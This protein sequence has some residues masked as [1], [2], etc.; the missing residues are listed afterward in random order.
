MKYQKKSGVYQILNL[1]NQKCYVGSSKNIHSRW[2]DHRSMLRNNK[3]GNKHLQNAWNK[4][5]EDEFIFRILEQI[6]YDKTL[7]EQREDYWI[8]HFDSTNEEK[9]YN[10][11]TAQ[12]GTFTDKWKDQQ[13]EKV[14]KD[15]DYYLKRKY[16]QELQGGQDEFIQ[17]LLDNQDKKI[18]IKNFTNYIRV[19][20]DSDIFYFQKNPFKKLS[21][22]EF[23]HKNLIYEIQPDSNKIVNT[24]KS[25]SELLEYYPQINK[26]QLERILY[27][28]K[29][30]ISTKGKIF[31]LKSNYDISK[32]YSIRQRKEKEIL[33]LD[34]EGNILKT[35]SSIKHILKENPSYSQSSLQAVLSK[36]LK[37]ETYP[38]IYIHNLSF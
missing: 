16:V 9:G 24:F 10:K 12:Q 36:N 26:N 18:K 25:P 31:V 35:Y 5:G 27:Y 34:K 7:I 11:Q 8:S 23:E 29:G 30:N 15:K 38:Y 1:T 6:E 4:D 20:L 22:N 2:S 28:P 14:I 19:E 21:R 3:H 37:S 32:I 17:F 33:K 13:K